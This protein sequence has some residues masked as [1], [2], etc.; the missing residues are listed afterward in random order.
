MRAI[1]GERKGS[2]G[3]RENGA[4]HLERFVGAH[5]EFRQMMAQGHEVE[6]QQRDQGQLSAI[7]PARLR[8]LHDIWAQGRLP[9]CAR[10]RSRGKLR[11]DSNPTLPGAILLP[12]LP[13]EGWMPLMGDSP[14]AS[15]GVAVRRS[16]ARAGLPLL[17]APSHSTGA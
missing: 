13:G 3:R 1:V 16:G 5:P 10:T 4:G 11:R 6:R 7:A 12:W 17:M 2:V 8:A 9:R 14:G 15:W